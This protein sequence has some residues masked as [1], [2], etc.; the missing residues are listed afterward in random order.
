MN[1][2][3]ITAIEKA[4]I[5][6]FCSGDEGNEY[7][8]RE[9]TIKC[10]EGEHLQM[11]AFDAVAVVLYFVMVPGIFCYA[12]FV[13]VPQ[14]GLNDDRLN[15]NFGFL[16]QRFEARIYWWEVIDMIRKVRRA[17]HDPSQLPLGVHVH[18]PGISLGWHRPHR[19][20]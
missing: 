13:L 9:P 11:L 18:A 7:L 14:H 12:L 16:W 2:Y 8:T 5:P 20:A 6:M 1:A 15:K 4:F 10:W 3:Y 19:W 17:P